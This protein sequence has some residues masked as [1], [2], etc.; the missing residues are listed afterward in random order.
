MREGTSPPLSR[1]STPAR[2]TFERFLGYSKI[3]WSDQQSRTEFAAGS[4]QPPRSA[5]SVCDNN[6]GL[7]LGWSVDF[8]LAPTSGT[9]KQQRWQR[10]SIFGFLSCDMTV[11]LNK[12]LSLSLCQASSAQQ[13]SARLDSGIVHQRGYMLSCPPAMSSGRGR[14]SILRSGDAM[15]MT[16]QGQILK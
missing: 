2:N 11:V 8:V 4:V 16:Y 15:T 1:S 9:M 5:H 3:V 14:L 13:T 12:P 7:L 6:V 10:S